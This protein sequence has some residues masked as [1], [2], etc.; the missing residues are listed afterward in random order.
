MLDIRIVRYPS[1][2]QSVDT[3]CSL[4]YNYLLYHSCE[5]EQNISE[6]LIVVFSPRG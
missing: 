6:Y 3:L 5:A 2:T 4:L 1:L